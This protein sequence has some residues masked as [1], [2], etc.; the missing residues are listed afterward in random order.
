[1]KVKP[2]HYYNQLDKNEIVTVYLE[3]HIQHTNTLR[4]HN[5]CSL[6]IPTLFLLTNL[7]NKSFRPFRVTTGSA[8]QS[9]LSVWR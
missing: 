7:I 9:S 6:F 3:I 2:A 1:M 8:E 5:A 4:G